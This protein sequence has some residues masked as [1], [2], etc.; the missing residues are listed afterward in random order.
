[1]GETVLDVP[2]YIH[3]PVAQRSARGAQQHPAVSEVSALFARF[4][5]FR[6]FSECGVVQFGPVGCLS[7]HSTVPDHAHFVC[8]S[9]DAA[10]R[11]A[12]QPPLAG[13]IEVIWI[14]GGVQVYK[15][16]DGEGGLETCSHRRYSASA[17]WSCFCNIN[18][19]AFPLLKFCFV[20]SW[21]GWTGAPLVRLNLPDW[22]HGGVP[23]WRILPRVWHTAV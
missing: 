2:S 3:L 17:A 9:L 6:R 21:S 18:I 22:H 19:T 4:C 16:A 15:V 7:F 20:C 5:V 10:V 11:L 1:M 8:K 14:V 13:L 12:S 23:M